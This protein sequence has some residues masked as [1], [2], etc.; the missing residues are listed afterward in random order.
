MSAKNSV[1]Y[2]STYNTSQKN[3]QHL[4]Y[5]AYCPL[6]CGGVNMAHKI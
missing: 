6:N 5:K 3:C 4:N 2:M 1:N